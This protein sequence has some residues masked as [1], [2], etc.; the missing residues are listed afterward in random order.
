MLKTVM[1]GARTNSVKS[2]E[3]VKDEKIVP[4]KHNAVT[5]RISVLF[6]FSWNVYNMLK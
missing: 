6:D 5:K 3:T 1:G 2:I 4:F